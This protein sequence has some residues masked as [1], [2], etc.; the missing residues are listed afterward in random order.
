[1]VL[2]KVYRMM[3][4]L[5]TAVIGRIRE[6][7]SVAT[8]SGIPTPMDLILF[9]GTTLFFESRCEDT[10][11]AFGDYKHGAVQVLL[12]LAVIRS[13]LFTGYEVFPDHMWERN[14]VLPVLRTLHPDDTRQ[15]VIMA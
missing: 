15:A 13:G 7:I 14:R 6:Q 5:D 11:R 4:H 1:M 9:D 8:R 2:E 12:A 10:L 3:D